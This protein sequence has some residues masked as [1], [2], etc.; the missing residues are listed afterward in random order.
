[1]IIEVTCTQD[2][3]DPSCFSSPPSAIQN[4]LCLRLVLADHLR[5]Q[6]SMFD[7]YELFFALF[8]LFFQRH[9]KVL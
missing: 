9:R 5:V 2:R 4:Q 6:K 3:I 1:M 8:C 7:F